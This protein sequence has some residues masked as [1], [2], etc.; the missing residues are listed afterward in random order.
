VEHERKKGK[1]RREAG[2]RVLIFALLACSV[3]LATPTAVT[4]RS[5]VFPFHFL[6]ISTGPA[7]AEPCGRDGVHDFLRGRGIE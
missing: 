3:K 7:R 5:T 2:V 4:S 6:T 1:P